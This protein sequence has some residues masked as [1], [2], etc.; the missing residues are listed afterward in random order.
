MSLALPPARWSGSQHDA[1][2]WAC[3]DK[4]ECGS[5]HWED[6]CKHARCLGCCEPRQAAVSGGFCDGCNAIN[7]EG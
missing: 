4:C 6:E 7:E 2:P 3:G 5:G 1:D